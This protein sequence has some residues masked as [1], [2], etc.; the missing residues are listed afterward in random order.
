MRH[1]LPSSWY[2]R[3]HKPARQPRL[4]PVSDDWYRSSAWDEK[5]RE[6]FEVRLSR[7]R[8]SRGE[9]LRIKA[10]SLLD[11]GML[12]EGQ[13][14]LLRILDEDPDSF[15]A[16]LATELLGDIARS[17][18]RLDE[19]EKCYRAVLERWP[20]LSATTGMVEVSLAEMLIERDG[21]ESAHEALGLL[22]SCLERS[23][24]LDSDLFRWHVALARASEAIGDSETQRRAARTALSLA[25]K[26][27]AFP[28][29]PEVGLVSADESTRAWL[30][31]LA[32]DG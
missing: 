3:G 25:D 11:A 30:R 31:D 21:S 12:S 24:M 6:D 20:D 9:Y 18:G 1:I 14:L 13:G 7:S 27:P 2:N 29:H 8:S 5:S 32:A 23:T 17:Q 28:R 22:N 26:A 4:S 19:A 10:V 16:P 15:E